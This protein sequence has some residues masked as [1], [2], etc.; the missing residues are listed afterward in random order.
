MPEENREHWTDQVLARGPARFSGET[1]VTVMGLAG[2]RSV[3]RLALPDEADTYAKFCRHTYASATARTPRLAR[4][5]RHGYPLR[6]SDGHPVDDL[7]RPI[8]RQGISRQFTQ[9]LMRGPRR[10][11]AASPALK[12]VRLPAGLWPTFRSRW[13]LVSL[14][15]W[16]VA[17]ADQLLRIRQRA[18]RRRRR[19]DRLLLCRP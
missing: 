16:P 7:G 18:R 2:A 11:L 19:L 9:Q 12:C 15:R 10:P 13:L 14:L 8:Q 5:D 3:A 17:A 4:V 6:A 1:V